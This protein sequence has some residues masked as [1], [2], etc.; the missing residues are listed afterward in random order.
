LTASATTAPPARRR[1]KRFPIIRWTLVAFVV[2][3]A[4]FVS[5]LML[6]PI[7]LAVPP[8]PQST[9]LL[10]SAGTVYA[11]IRSPEVRE[12]IPAEQIPDVMRNAIVAAED[13]RFLQH[14]GVDPVALMRAVVADLRSKSAQQGGSTITQQ[15]VKNVY[16]GSEKTAMRKVKEAALAV[17]LEQQKS[18]QEILTAYL[19]GVFFGNGVYG[20]Q[21]ASKY[22][23]GKPAKNLTLGEAAMLAGIVPAPSLRNP[24]RNYQTARA[25]QLETLNKMSELGM[26][27]VRQ[28]SDAFRVPPVIARKR[29]PELPTVAP[30]FADL[31]KAELKA[32]FAEELG[33]DA[34][35]EERL[36]SGLR[37]KTTL[38]LTLQ[39]AVRN[40]VS[41][42][43]TDP[44]D[45]DVAVSVLDFKTGD[46]KAV[47]SSRYTRGGF[48]YATNGKRSPG[49]VMKAFALPAAL[50][51]GVKADDVYAD[52]RCYRYGRGRDDTACNYEQTGGGRKT[53][54]RATWKSSN[55]VWLQIT[56]RIGQQKVVDTATKMGVQGRI[57]PGATMVLG[58]GVEVTPLSVTRGLA[59]VAN[60]G[61]RQGLRTIL[62]IRQGDGVSTKLTGAVVKAQTPKSPSVRVLPAPIAAETARILTGVVE[63][64]TATR[65]RQEFDVFGKTGTKDN[66]TDAWFVGC[67][68]E[69]SL[70]VGVWMGHGKG[71]RP[72]GRVQGVRSV[73]GGSLPAMIF[74]QFFEQAEKLEAA[75]AQ[76]TEGEPTVSP[77]PT[78][79]RRRPTPTP[80]VVVVPP[81]P[82]PS[83]TPSPTSSPTP[84]TQ[85]SDPVPTLTGGGSPTPT[86]SAAPP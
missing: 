70:C 23:F 26:I 47:H 10:D 83:R 66:N 14:K 77:S 59:T 72:M 42:V 8:P 36:F 22:Y 31:V 20:V 12:P 80:T 82:T 37:V 27:D 3:L 19:N 58:G 69:K 45:P 75:K 43:L 5:G 40:A 79:R 44:E 4:C 67:A 71:L 56:R 50:M 85:P 24:V 34:A 74:D 51:N 25:K 81:S 33:D 46:L 11:T 1:R 52:P 68:P 60:G 16:V 61:V 18:K 48:N 39:Q 57:D 49:S 64:G 21:A 35:A 15:Y 32:Q 63:R 9:V 78:R 7:D 62:E 86:G 13:Q 76:L 54:E 29:D 53:V 73:T 84:S 28:A 65:A 17:R 2:A 55:T 30:E 41:G 38:D 6:A